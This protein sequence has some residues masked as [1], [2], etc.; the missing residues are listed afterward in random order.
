MSIRNVPFSIRHEPL[1]VGRPLV[2]LDL[3]IR[4]L[5]AARARLGVALDKDDAV[6]AVLGAA[7]RRPVRGRVAAAHGHVL[8]RRLDV[9][10]NVRL[11]GPVVPAGY[12]VRDAPSSATASRTRGRPDVD[13]GL[14][15]EPFGSRR[16]V[17]PSWRQDYTDDINNVTV[18]RTRVISQICLLVVEASYFGRH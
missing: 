1:E 16:R 14:A 17:R 5:L 9:V 11:D 12:L 8:L 7:G 15:T 6:E 2:L 4:A 3:L 18:K 13:G 10:V